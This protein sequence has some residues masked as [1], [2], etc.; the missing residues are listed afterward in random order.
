MTRHRA[1]ASWRVE[2]EIKKDLC[3]ITFEP[4]KNQSI[5]GLLFPYF[6]G[7]VMV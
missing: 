5:F 6:W 2:E 4:Q 1:S 7:N 3:K